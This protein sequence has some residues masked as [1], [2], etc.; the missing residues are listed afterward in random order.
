MYRLLD[1]LLIYMRDGICS[2]ERFYKFRLLDAVTEQEDL[3]YEF[4]NLQILG[5]DIRILKKECNLR[6]V[7]IEYN[8]LRQY[9]IV[10]SFFFRLNMRE[11]K[12]RFENE[13]QETAAMQDAERVRGAR[14]GKD[15]KRQGGG[16]L[17]RPRVKSCT[18]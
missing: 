4:E 14:L 1:D 15:S 18:V 6:K 11:C 2:I 3:L 9:G 12:S 8:K 13:E 17:F 7:T 5:Q 10:K 16:Y